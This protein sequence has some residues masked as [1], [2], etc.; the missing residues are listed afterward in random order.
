MG[1]I[2]DVSMLTNRAVIE[3]AVLVILTL[4]AVLVLLPYPIQLNPRS[5]P[6]ILRIP[7]KIP[8]L[9]IPG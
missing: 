6:G 2:F 9:P 7:A 8:T 5:N 4:A 1:R 3:T